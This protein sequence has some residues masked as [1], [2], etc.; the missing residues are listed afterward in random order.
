MLFLFSPAKTLDYNSKP[1]VLAFN[2]DVS[3]QGKDLYAFW[4][5]TISRQL[6]KRLSSVFRPRLD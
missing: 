2:G 1:T 5:E 6:D 3:T 4:G